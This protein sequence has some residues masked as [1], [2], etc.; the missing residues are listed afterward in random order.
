MMKYKPAHLL[1]YANVIL[2]AGIDIAIGRASESVKDRKSGQC[3][4]FDLLDTGPTESPG[5]SDEELPDAKPWSES[6]MLAAEKELIGFFI[7]G[8]PLARHEWTL[9]HFAL[10]RMKDIQQLPPGTRTRVG[11]MVVEVRKRFTKKDQKPMATFRIEGLEGSIGAIAFPGPFEQ[12][13]SLL[14][15]DATLMF[16]GVIMEEENGD[17]KL[18]VMEIFPLEQ[19]T[20][21]FC[22]RVSIHLPEMGVNR[23]VTET[24]RDIATEY[25]GST[26]LHLC[27]EFVD[28]PKVFINADHA[29]R[30]RPCAELERRIEQTIGEGLVYIAAKSDALRNPPPERKWKGR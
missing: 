8:H 28:G 18:Q 12:Y 1:E 30:V 24:L 22:D 17:Q 3:S 23:H 14:A 16:G 13:G 5:S 26:P 6:E 19:A 9:N 25:R 15:D 27:I 20:G 4:M 2:F 21:I 29:F 7:S 10:T 11:G